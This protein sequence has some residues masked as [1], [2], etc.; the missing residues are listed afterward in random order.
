M[1]VWWG[2][3]AEWVEMD[4]AR[5]TD[6][7]LVPSSQMKKTFPALTWEESM[8][9]MLL[10]NEEVQHEILARYHEGKPVRI[11]PTCLALGW[12]RNLIDQGSL[13]S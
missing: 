6:N 1:H 8:S 5:P 9:A 2:P 11:L 13:R 12:A 3:Y 10:Y 4:R 7:G